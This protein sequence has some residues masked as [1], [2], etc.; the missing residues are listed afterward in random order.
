MTSSVL[1]FVHEQ[2]VAG[3]IAHS[4]PISIQTDGRAGR[5]QSA[6]ALDV[7]I[8]LKVLG[9]KNGGQR[10]EIGWRARHQPLERSL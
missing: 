6:R 8:R 7:L 10:F 2:E 4:D 1:V 3:L 5:K 9:R